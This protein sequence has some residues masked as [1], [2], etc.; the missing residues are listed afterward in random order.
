MI[1]I[2][3]ATGT[4]MVISI[5]IAVIKVW[6]RAVPPNATFTNRRETTPS[7]STTIGPAI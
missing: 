2:A 5:V 1:A 3:I 7:I 4:P 6:A